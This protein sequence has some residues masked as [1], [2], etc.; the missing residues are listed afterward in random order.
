MRVR[1]GAVP[2]GMRF[3]PR[4]G[5][6]PAVF[7]GIFFRFVA[8]APFGPG[9]LAVLRPGLIAVVGSLAAGILLGVPMGAALA[10][11]PRW[12]VARGPLRGLPAAV[13]AGVLFQAEVAVVA[14]VTE[15]GYG[16]T[17]LAFLATPVVAV[18]AAVHSDDIAGRTRRHPWL[19]SPG[20]VRS[21]VD[22][23]AAPDSWGSKGR[24]LLRM[25][26]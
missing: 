25:L 2:R 12:L 16:P 13:L 5:V 20:T 10:V 21:L 19:W 11:A 1:Q 6:I 18:A 15:G 4:V 3:G 22:L 14:V 17:L 26:W 8:V 24:R 23:W 7:W 9:P